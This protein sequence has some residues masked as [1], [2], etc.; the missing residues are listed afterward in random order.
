[1]SQSE[2]TKTNGGTSW[3]LPAERKKATFNVD[4]M[5]NVIDGGEEKTKRR[6]FLL[7]PMKGVDLSDRYFWGREEMLKNHVKHFVEVHEGYW[8]R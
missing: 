4:K 7:S 8:D 6:K 2:G 1:M 5:T 3:I